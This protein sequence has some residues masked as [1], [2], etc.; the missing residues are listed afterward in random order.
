MVLV[1]PPV[2][3]YLLLVLMVAAVAAAM[4]LKMLPHKA[5]HPQ[6]PRLAPEGRFSSRGWSRLS[7]LKHCRLMTTF[8][9]NFFFFFSLAEPAVDPKRGGRVCCDDEYLKLIIE[10]KAQ[11]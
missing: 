2:P 1:M 7:L 5:L 10:T 3:C 8:L 9:G 4:L 11:T 6:R